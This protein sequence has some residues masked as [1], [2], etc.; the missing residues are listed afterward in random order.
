VRTQRTTRHSE[1]VVL[2]A[3]HGLRERLLPAG[4]G[5]F[6]APAWS[7]DGRWLLLPWPEADQWLFLRPEGTRR[8]SA[9]ANIARQFAPGGARPAFPR[10]VTWCCPSATR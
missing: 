2:D 7:P 3:A 6:G 8:V 9:V 1:V 10:T 5:H 4:P